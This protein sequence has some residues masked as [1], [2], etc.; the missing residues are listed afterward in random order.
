MAMDLAAEGVLAQGAVQ[1]LAE[2]LRLLGL[3]R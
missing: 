3:I 1:M 2:L